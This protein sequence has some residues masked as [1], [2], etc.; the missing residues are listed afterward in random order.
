MTDA[1][2][3]GEVQ[4][5]SWGEKFEALVRFSSH[6]V[7]RSSDIEQFKT[8]RFVELRA[9]GETAAA[10]SVTLEEWRLTCVGFCLT[11]QSRR[12]NRELIEL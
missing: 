11:F 7:E 4:G 3:W 12:D 8:E 9:R 6:H 10:E 5:G 2:V 1:K